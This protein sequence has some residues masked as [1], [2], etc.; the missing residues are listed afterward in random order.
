M[1]PSLSQLAPEVLLLRETSQQLS[2]RKVRFK[3]VGVG[4][5]LGH[6]SEASSAPWEVGGE[7]GELGHQWG[8]GSLLGGGWEPC[9]GGLRRF[10]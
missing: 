4:T 5:N 6:N 3:D 9:G 2:E 10:R 1:K 8:E 7:E